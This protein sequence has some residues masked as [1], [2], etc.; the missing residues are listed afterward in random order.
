MTSISID[1]M[2]L[3]QLSENWPS[4]VR[5]FIDWHLHCIG[6]PVARFHTLSDSACE[7]GYPLEEL[8]RAVMNAI[9]DGPDFV[10]ILPVSVPRAHPSLSH[11]QTG[12][13]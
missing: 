3:S 5:V 11:F 8:R 7:H 1:D 2:S 6:C 9:D 10:S 12:S 13:R 4:V